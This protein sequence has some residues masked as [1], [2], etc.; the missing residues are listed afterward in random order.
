MELFLDQIRNLI[1][2]QSGTL[3]YHLVIIII[4]IA[5]L[6]LGIRSNHKKS[7]SAF[8]RS[9]IGLAF[10]L[11][12]QFI[13]FL[14]ALLSWQNVLN[15][16]L[17]MPILE[18][19][20]ISFNILWIIWLWAFPRPNII[21]DTIMVLLNGVILILFAFNFW[22]WSKEFSNITFNNTTLDWIW[23]IFSIVIIFIG[24]FPILYKRSKL[25]MRGFTSLLII[26]TGQVIHIFLFPIEG[27]YS[28]I[29]RMAML[30][31]FPLLLSL[32]H[33]NAASAT[34]G[35]EKYLPQSMINFFNKNLTDLSESN[36]AVFEK[37]IPGFILNLSKAEH[38][39]K[40]EEIIPSQQI[41]ITK[42]PFDNEDIES[43]ITVLFDQKQFPNLT[44]ALESQFI[45]THKNVP[46]FKEEFRT[47]SKSIN[48]LTTQ[49]VMI[50]P[51]PIH[52]E[53]KT[54]MMILR[55][56]FTGWDE[57]SQAEIS[58]TLFSLLMMYQKKKHDYQLEK[59]LQ[60]HLK[61]NKLTIHSAASQNFQA[62]Q[63]EFNNLT[64]K[65]QTLLT[66]FTHIK[67][68]LIYLSER[69]E[70]HSR[71]MTKTERNKSLEILKSWLDQAQTENGLLQAEMEQLLRE[72]KSLVLE[73]DHYREIKNLEEYYASIKHGES[74][75]LDEQTNLNET[76]S[77]AFELLLKISE[78]DETLEQNQVQ[79]VIL[80]ES[81]QERMNNIHQFKV[82]KSDKSINESSF[83]TQAE[84]FLEDISASKDILK[85]QAQLQ[86]K[87]E[88]TFMDNMNLKDNFDQLT[89]LN[90]RN[91]DEINQIFKQ[92]DSCRSQNKEISLI[93]N[94]VQEENEK[95]RVKMLH[96]ISQNK[97]DSLAIE[98]L[99]SKMM[100]ALEETEFFKGKVEQVQNQ[101]HQIRIESEVSKEGLRE[102]N[103]L[104]TTLLQD[105][106]HP[107]S[108]ISGLINLLANQYPTNGKSDKL[109]G[110]IHISLR[111]IQGQ[112][113]KLITCTERTGEILGLSPAIE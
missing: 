112:I 21:V 111:T 80:L 22:I 30:A 93:L 54:S 66:K 106:L 85:E 27:D 49:K 81:I 28:P 68:D 71:R 51:Y 35:K 15:A 79:G 34:H 110:Q 19:T 89:R 50:M 14:C 63:Q 32:S 83:I 104:I 53:R 37:I 92:V 109:L 98:N 4:I 64:Q 9:V 88:E 97:G 26:L 103:Q 23:G 56:S 107:I 16:R 95:M 25:W 57:I 36:P 90:H 18:R 61:S 59:N 108:S 113:E 8:R 46:A 45:M 20:M 58:N 44:H 41:K 24:I 7:T 65:H 11:A 17:L 60:H 39:F 78:M 70:L 13:I 42:L 55:N 77:S 73:I 3:L 102:N 91:Y 72:N 105:T 31:S 47:I 62:L 67:K 5:S 29:L 43:S 75:P 84:H 38:C 6:H 12:G 86:K 40:L 101:L 82:K 69:V 33:K 48:T 96:T 76:L 94:N 1:L 74:Q 87:L 100:A 99:K 10:L 52:P 2:S